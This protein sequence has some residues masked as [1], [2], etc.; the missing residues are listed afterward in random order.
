M[1]IHRDKVRS[2]AIRG[3]HSIQPLLLHT[4]RNQLKWFKR[5]IR[6][7]LECLPLESYVL[8]VVQQEVQQCLV[9]LT[10]KN[11][12]NYYNSFHCFADESQ[13]RLLC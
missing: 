7:P 2:S 4:E 12:N 13:K 9:D 3:P 11:D 1:L 5:L 8:T 10:I 6:M